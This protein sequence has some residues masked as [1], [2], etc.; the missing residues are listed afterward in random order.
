MGLQFLGP[1]M[2]D[3]STRAPRNPGLTSK[4]CTDSARV[5]FDSKDVLWSVGVRTKFKVQRDDIGRV[6]AEVA[7]AIKK[8]EDELERVVTWSE[9]KR[10]V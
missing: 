9:S 10:C 3:P 7:E 4:I 6:I 1:G 5:R 2:H 8:L